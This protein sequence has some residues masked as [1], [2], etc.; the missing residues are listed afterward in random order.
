MVRQ[1][2]GGYQSHNLRWR[3]MRRCC[4]ILLL[5]ALAVQ[6]DSPQHLGVA[7]CA[8]S[9]CHG[10]V[11][12]SE[13]YGAQMTEYSQWFRNDRHS[14]AYM[15]LL[16]D[17]SKR[18]AG[19][20]GLEDPARAE[21]CLNCH[22]DNVPDA[23]RGEAFQLSDGVGCESCHGGARGWIG[24]HYG[25]DASHA[26]SVALGLRDLTDPFVLS[27]LCTSCHLGD[28]DRLATHRIMAA[29]HPRLRFEMA[30]YLS[31]MPAHHQIDDDYR[32]RKSVSSKLQQWFSGIIASNMAYLELILGERR[33]TGGPF[34]EFAMFDCFSCH[35]PIP[36]GDSAGYPK[37]YGRGLSLPTFNTANFYLLEE[38]LYV[39]RHD[40]MKAY[41]ESM[42]AF[43]ALNGATGADYK[44]VA[45]KLL[46]QLRELQLSL[47]DMSAK[48]LSGKL[49]KELLNSEK[50]LRF[51]DYSSAEQYFMTL[52]TLLRSMEGAPPPALLDGLYAV[53][54]GAESF[55]RE[56]FLVEIGRLGDYLQ[57]GGTL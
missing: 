27:E 3:I 15:T 26:K 10:N 19:N 51:S 34:P 39:L 30:T 13:K 7:S 29:G 16:S 50:A 5:L 31:V 41:S 21:A 55:D 9:V 40:A 28:D 42:K 8:S 43:L 12:P 53:F 37:S 23:R 6:A 47:P 14:Q 4:G 36:R 25:K 24:E 57:K 20:L 48:D 33:Q 22:S 38:G 52:E 35:K 2:L 18:I 17:H 32:E 54:T 1:R 45:E 56:R 44:P 46:A 49:L 11:L